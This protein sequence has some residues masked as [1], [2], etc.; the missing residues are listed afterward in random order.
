MKFYKLVQIPDT[1]P[2]AI[3]QPYVVGQPTVDGIPIDYGIDTRDFALTVAD[4][5][6][7]VHNLQKLVET[8]YQIHSYVVIE[9]FEKLIRA[10]AFERT[11]YGKSAAQDYMIASIRTA[12]STYKTNGLIGDLY[13]SN[14][15]A[16]AIAAGSFT[17]HF[18]GGTYTITITE[19]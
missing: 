10:R 13:D 7:S 19:A 4:G 18:V 3:D 1:E 9:R 14:L 16:L 8:P 5:R 17:H 12:Y 15:A 2:L 11:V 6:V